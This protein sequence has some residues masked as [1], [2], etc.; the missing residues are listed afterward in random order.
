MALNLLLMATGGVA[1]KF[2]TL[3]A[4]TKLV[5]WLKWFLFFFVVVNTIAAL[6]S[7][8]LVE[9]LMVPITALYATCLYRISKFSDGLGTHDIPWPAGM[10]VIAITPGFPG[11]ISFELGGGCFGFGKTDQEIMNGVTRI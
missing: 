8:T 4:I 3:P 7:T 11:R 5:D 10:S 2:I 6:F 9:V 1:G